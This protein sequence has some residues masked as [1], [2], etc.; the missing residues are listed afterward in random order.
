MIRFVTTNEGKF[1]E[2]FALLAEG[3]NVTNRVS[4]NSYNGGIQSRLFGMPQSAGNARQIQ[5]GARFD[6]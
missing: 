3:F 6:F 5:L 2:V 4:F 1:R